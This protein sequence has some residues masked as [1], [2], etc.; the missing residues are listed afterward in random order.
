MENEYTTIFEEI[1]PFNKPIHIKNKSYILSRINDFKKNFFTSFQRIIIIIIY[2]YTINLLYQ[3]VSITYF[4]ILLLFSI[5]TIINWVIFVLISQPIMKVFSTFFI[6]FHA[7][8][9]Y[10]ITSFIFFPLGESF[11]QIIVTRSV[12]M[13]IMFL[14]TIHYKIYQIIYSLINKIQSLKSS[15]LN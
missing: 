6:L 15:T 5:I 14:F 8:C 11:L 9:T 1:D 10:K 3:K 7:I 12:L 13:L 2:L 4:S